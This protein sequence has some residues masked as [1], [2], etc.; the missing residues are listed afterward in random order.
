MTTVARKNYML[1]DVETTFVALKRPFTSKYGSSYSVSIELDKDKSSP[2]NLAILSDLMKQ[3]AKG[4]PVD[5][6]DETG[7]VSTGRFRLSFYSDVPVPVADGQGNIIPLEQLPNIDKG[8]VINL[9]FA[10]VKGNYGV[11][12]YI[13]GVQIVKL[14]EFVA[15]SSGGVG[16]SVSFE[17]ASDYAFSEDPVKGEKTSKKGNADFESV[18][19]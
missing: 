9:K 3:M 15:G 12:K 19:D 4:G 5:I 10:L 1:K 11:N 18:F 2:E 14:K 7:L 17:K 16:S 13:Q 6:K 8:T